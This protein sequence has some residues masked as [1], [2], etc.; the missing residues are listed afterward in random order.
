MAVQKLRGLAAAKPVLLAGQEYYATDTNTLYIG[1]GDTTDSVIK[2]NPSKSDVGL[3]NVDNTSDASKP[4]STAQQAA[5]DLK[6]NANDVSV[7]NTRTPTNSTVNFLKVTGDIKQ[8]LIN[9]GFQSADQQIAPHVSLPN[10]FAIANTAGIYS[11]F[12][13]LN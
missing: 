10:N 11:W 3:G 5:L 6:L 7:T 4:V 1:K 8:W 13:K 12:Y 2:Q 9:H